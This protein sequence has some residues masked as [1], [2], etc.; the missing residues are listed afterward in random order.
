MRGQ[1]ELLEVVGAFQTARRFAHLLHGR[2]QQGDQDGE[3]RD[4]HQKLDQCEAAPPSRENAWR[5]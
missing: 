2:E 1:P 3:N 5:H 4:H